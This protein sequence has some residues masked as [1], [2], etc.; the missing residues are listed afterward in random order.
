[1]FW[2]RKK[3]SKKKKILILLDFEN[4]QRNIKMT[5]TPENFSVITGFDNILKRI[6]SEVGGISNVFVFA[7]PH[8]ASLQGENFY[9]LGFFTI[10]CP[11]VKDKKGREIDTTDDILIKF[12]RKIIY[13][14]NEY[15]HLCIGSG[16][17]DFAPLVREAIRQ[18]LKIII[19][20]GGLGSIS[21][22]LIKL[23]DTNPI[24][25]KKMV[26][27]FSPTENQ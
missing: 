6:S 5:A 23:A 11:R 25:K 13:Q 16:D 15:T 9:E 22:E 21:S 17:K 26:Y 27:I 19:I 1:M 14:F 4:I 8:T 2:K 10:F 12:G 24:T 3:G 20:A 7:P 18:G